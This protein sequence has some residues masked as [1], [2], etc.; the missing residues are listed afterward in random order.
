MIGGRPGG[1]RETVGRRR[2]MRNGVLISR[3]RRGVQGGGC[4]AFF[5]REAPRW[6]TRPVC[7]QQQHVCIRWQ[8]EM[9]EGGIK[10]DV[11]DGEVT[12][13]ERGEVR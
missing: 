2:K 13:V 7:M 12:G 11:L 1:T 4:G 3:R 8:R 9:W 6:G 5:R 10:L